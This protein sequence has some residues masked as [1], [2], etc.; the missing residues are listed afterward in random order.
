MLRESLLGAQHGVHS[1]P[2]VRALIHCVFEPGE[3]DGKIDSRA[4]THC[5][6]SLLDLNEA[7]E[8]PRRGR[9]CFPNFYWR[10]VSK[11]D[12]DETVL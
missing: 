1:M 11:T 8:Q 7:A 2:S 3:R 10:K 6:V 12:L 9:I 5:S 4:D